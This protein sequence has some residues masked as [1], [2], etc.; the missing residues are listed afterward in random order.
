MGLVPRPKGR[1]VAWAGVAS[2][3]AALR[4]FGSALELCG[5]GLTAFELCSERSMELPLRHMPILQ[6]PL[7]GR[8]A[9]YV[10][11]E[12]S[13]GRSAEDASSLCEQLF[14][15]AIEKGLVADAV[16]A[17]N[18]AQ[19]DAFWQIREAMSDAQRPEGASIKHDI[20]V[21]VAA[22]PDFIEEGR[23]AIEGVAPEARMVCFG[24]MGDG[25]L[26][27]NVSQPVGADPAEFLALYRRMN[28]AVHAVV[29]RFGGSISAE[30]GVGQMK[31]TELLAT[32]PPV[33]IELMRRVKKAFDPAGI[34]NPGK[35]I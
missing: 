14:A 3:A 13:S 35:T 17:Q 9:W 20:S 10:L 12:I 11:I 21:P 5:S 22:I 8:H 24:H 1:E 16:V 7:A 31:R 30:H 26:H 15:M 33:A 2:P 29:R 18:L 23:R 19:A 25:N 6:R 34:M 27:F 32:E 28:D 4:L